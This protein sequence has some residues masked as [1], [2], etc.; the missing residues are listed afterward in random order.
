[1]NLSDMSRSIF[2]AAPMFESRN[3]SAHSGPE[4]IPSLPDPAL[5]LEVAR[6][7]LTERV[8]LD[9]SSMPSSTG[10]AEMRGLISLCR[11]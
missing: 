10:S 9:H 11:E 4:L 8:R 3:A 6:A 1:M 2:S 5:G 7:L